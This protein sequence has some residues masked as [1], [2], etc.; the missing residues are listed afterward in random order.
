MNTISA[1]YQYYA[2]I[3][4]L[5]AI[6]KETGAYLSDVCVDRE[7]CV[8]IDEDNEDEFYNAM[9]QSA[10]NSA[11]MRAEDLGMNIN[12]LIGRTIY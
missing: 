8:G 10:C 4:E 11:G 2:L 3:D 6:E 12:K 5:Q 9:Y 7:N 1:K